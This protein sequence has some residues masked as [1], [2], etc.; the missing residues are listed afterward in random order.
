MRKP[1]VSTAEQGR[2]CHAS[3]HHSASLSS[4]S[5]F[6]LVALQPTTRAAEPTRPCPPDNNPARCCFHTSSSSFSDT[7]QHVSWDHGGDSSREDPADSVAPRRAPASAQQSVSA[8]SNEKIS[9]SVPAIRDRSA[10]DRRAGTSSL[11]E[12]IRGGPPARPLWEDRRRHLSAFRCSPVTA[13]GVAVD[14]LPI[15][16]EDRGGAVRGAAPLTNAAVLRAA[17]RPRAWRP[18]S[19]RWTSAGG[20]LDDGMLDV[21]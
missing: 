4:L 5:V 3:V 11:T 20:V 13:S 9:S 2:S 8:S 14:R 19:R 12:G 17:G 1:A 16:G 15:V 7:N 18:R 10:R 21:R 6:L